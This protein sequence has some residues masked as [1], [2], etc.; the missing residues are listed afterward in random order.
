MIE[1]RLLAGLPGSLASGAWTQCKGPTA[2]VSECVLEAWGDG[3]WLPVK[4]LSSD[5]ILS[6]SYNRHQHRRGWGSCAART[7]PTGE[8]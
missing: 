6:P 8:G 3:G 4:G 2:S 7:I 1:D 5:P